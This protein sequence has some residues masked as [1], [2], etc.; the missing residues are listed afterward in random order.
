MGVVLRER[1]IVIGLGLILAAVLWVYFLADD[2]QQGPK[3]PPP[4][5]RVAVDVTPFKPDPAVLAKI[6]DA[7][8]LDR[9]SLEAEP[10]EHLLRRSYNITPNVA[11]ALGLG[12]DQPS[13]AALRADP[14]RHRGEYMWF[15]GQLEKF[16]P[17]RVHPMPRATAFFG[18]LR[19]SSGE[20]VMFWVSQP[21]PEGVKLEDPKR[22]WVRIE[23]FFM[24][25]QDDVRVGGDDLYDVPLLVGP[26]LRAD[27]PDWNPVDKLDPRI[28]DQVQNA[29]KDKEGI[30]RD[31]RDW[32]RM[33]HDSESMPLW[34]M[35]SFALNRRE[36]TLRNTTF[37]ELAEQYRKF[38]D[39]EF[40]PGHE[41]AIRGQLQ[42]SR[43]W[44]AQPNPVGIEYW[45]EV[46]VRIPRMGAK[47]VPIW[48]PERVELPRGTDVQCDGYFFK[49]YSYAAVSRPRPDAPPGTRVHTPLFVAAGL[50]RFE[51]EVSLV[52]SGIAWALAVMGVVVIVAFVMFSRRA[53]RES[54]LSS[55][56]MIERRRL[57][58]TN[59][60]DPA[61]SS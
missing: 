36:E 34:H 39:G 44:R 6:K 38:R 14:A 30:W 59:R 35:A 37:F 45:S 42:D 2:Q 8:A 26:E 24:K 46:W 13:I 60:S 3:L 40:Q 56:Q 27:Y 15:R 32:E 22:N 53:R 50:D 25:L 28:L 16:A 10:W 7:K 11:E 58:R 21:L 33:L 55:A 52:D 18:R 61:P 31:T 4:P 19:T 23:G 12:A 17:D 29:W 47:I 1:T 43:W 9:V 51:L 41:I 49:N 5:P 48:I 54:E 57:R 20:P